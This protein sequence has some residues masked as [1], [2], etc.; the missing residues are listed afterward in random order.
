MEVVC[1]EDSGER[2]NGFIPIM[3]FLMPVLS[4]GKKFETLAYQTTLPI[5]IFFT[6]DFDRA[7]CVSKLFASFHTY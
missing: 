5:M 2:R 4:A 1:L 3:N 7:R 6:I